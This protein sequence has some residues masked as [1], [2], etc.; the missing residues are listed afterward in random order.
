[1]PWVWNPDKEELVVK[2]RRLFPE[3]SGWWGGGWDDP[4]KE[5]IHQNKSWRPPT[6]TCRRD[7]ARWY[8]PRRE[9]RRLHHTP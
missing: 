6:T 8:L 4:V 9:L 5:V 1:M 7:G 3:V 2:E